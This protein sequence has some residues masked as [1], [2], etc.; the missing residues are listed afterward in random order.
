MG[1]TKRSVKIE[2]SGEDIFYPAEDVIDSCLWQ[3]LDRMNFEEEEPEAL[4]KYFFT[5]RFDEIE[6]GGYAVTVTASNK[7]S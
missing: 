3:A 5:M 7:R 4:L 2:I 1:I 6:E